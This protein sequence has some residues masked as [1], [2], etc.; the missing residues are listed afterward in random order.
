MCLP[1]QRSVWLRCNGVIT[2]S[3]WFE[4]FDRIFLRLDFAF[5]MPW[6][7]FVK[8]CNFCAFYCKA[9]YSRDASRSIPGFNL[10]SNFER[11][12]RLSS[13]AILFAFE[14]CSKLVELNDRNW[15]WEGTVLLGSSGIGAYMWVEC[16][17]FIFVLLMVSF[18]F[19]D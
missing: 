8:T 2:V 12:F 18:A 19:M 17:I 10:S 14:T 16:Y 9:A 7:L 1:A 4:R 15:E 3:T 6:N 11:N 5:I 13:F